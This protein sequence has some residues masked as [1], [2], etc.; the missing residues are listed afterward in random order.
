MLVYKL[1][2]RPGD[3][4]LIIRQYEVTKQTKQFMW[5]APRGIKNEA[6]MNYSVRVP[7]R[8]LDKEYYL[9]AAKAKAAR[10]NSLQQTLRTLEKGLVRVTNELNLVEAVEL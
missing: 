5:L 6:A 4:A 2:S 10:L 1:E 3:W 9:T 8:L 7:R